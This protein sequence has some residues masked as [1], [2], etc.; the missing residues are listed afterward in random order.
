MKKLGVV[1]SG[2]AAM[3]MLD[4]IFVEICRRRLSI[5]CRE[6]NWIRGAVN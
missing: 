6:V 4:E 5:E 3:M 1:L 2:T